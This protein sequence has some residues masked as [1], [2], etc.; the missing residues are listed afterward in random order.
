MHDLRTPPPGTGNQSNELPDPTM[1]KIPNL[2][3]EDGGRLTPRTASSQS[4]TLT[5]LLKRGV[6]IDEDDPILEQQS[7]F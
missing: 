5:K 2:D 1:V 4:I 6:I 7:S 3:N